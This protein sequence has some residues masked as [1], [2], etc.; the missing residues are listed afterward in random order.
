MPSAPGI[1]QS[2]IATS[3]SY[4]RE[5]VDGVVAA[6]DR[7]DVVAAVA[8]AE[9]DDLLESRVVFGD[10]DAH[11]AQPLTMRVGWAKGSLC[12]QPFASVTARWSAR[13]RRRIVAP[14]QDPQIRLPRS[15]GLITAG[16]HAGERLGQVVE[17]VDGPGF[18][19]LAERDLAERG[20]HA[21]SLEIGWRRHQLAQAADRLRAQLTEAHQQLVEGHIHVSFEHLEAVEGVER[22]G[23]AVAQDPL[24][25]RDPVVALA[26]DQVADD[27][28]RAPCR[29]VCRFRQPTSPGS[30]QAG[31]SQR[32]AS[33]RAGR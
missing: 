26:A 25:A 17:I 30:R 6:L 5:L 15:D 3:Y 29:R 12:P 16:G 11:R 14:K 8:Q 28:L 23:G 27:V 21:P 2:M 33:D 22:L 7:V 4:Q 9:R 18:Q 1:R 24:D 32:A 10:E 31:R 13:N 19:Q 20:M